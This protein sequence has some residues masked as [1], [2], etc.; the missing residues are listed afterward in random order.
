MA[1]PDDYVAGEQ[2]TADDANKIKRTIVMPNQTAGATIAGNTTPVPVYMLDS[3]N[4]WYACDANVQTALDFQGFAISAGS[5]GVAGLDIVFEG[6]VSGFTGLTQGARYYV[7]DAIGTIG[8]TIGTYE[9]YVGIALTTTQILIDKGTRSAMQYMGSEVGTT[10][11]N[12]DSA[13][14]TFTMPV[15]ARFAIL[16]M[17]F[18]DSGQSQLIIARVG[19]TSAAHAGTDGGTGG[20][21]GTINASL[22]TNTITATSNETANDN[23]ASCSGTAYYYR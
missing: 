11:G 15:D 17:S 8:T 21:N 5:N 2:L 9:C 20:T 6:I 19:M 18:T 10:G 22:V 4:E 12:T 13:T 3:D 16:Q 23:N 7:Q 1:H 14:C